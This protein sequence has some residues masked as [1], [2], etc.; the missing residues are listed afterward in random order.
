M[1]VQLLAAMKDA[2]G[3]VLIPHFYDGIEPLGP[4]ERAALAAAPVN[5][6]MLRQELA[7]GHVEGGGKRLL[8]LLNEPSLNING[9]ASGQ[10]GTRSTNSVPPTATANLD[11]RLVV[12]E[13]ATVQQQRVIDFIQSKGYFITRAEPTR[14]ELL[15]HTRVARIIA[16]PGENA[17][18]TPMDL[19]IATEVIAA[20]KSARGPVVLLP[21]M[22]GTVPLDAMERAAQTRTITIPIANH[23]DN[24]HAANENLR[25]QNLW[26]GVETMAALMDMP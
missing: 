25:L 21:T 5:D 10:V 14:E 4:V 11:L 16:E 7:L 13:D 12:G 18:R 22:G 17:S 15:Q 23:D 1:L 2:D 24:Q 20:V 8:E 26:D 6:E 19:P 9:I 3:H